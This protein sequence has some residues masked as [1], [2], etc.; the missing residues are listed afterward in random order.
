MKLREQTFCQATGD[1]NAYRRPHLW[2]CALGAD[3]H[4]LPVSQQHLPDLPYWLAS[5]KYD[6]GRMQA[7]SE[8]IRLS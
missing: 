6:R 3:L 8:I 2:V 1:T 4:F 7:P 5:F